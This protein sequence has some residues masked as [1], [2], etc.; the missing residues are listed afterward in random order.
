V[1]CGEREEQLERILRENSWFVDVLEIVRD[2]SPPSSAVGAGVI[3]N[4]VWDHLHG[5]RTLT[6]LNDVD[7]VYFDPADVSRARDRNLERK[8]GEQRPAIPWQVTNQAGVHL[9]YEAKFGYRI[10]PARSLADAVA[11]W[12]EPATAIAVSLAPGQS[13]RVVAPLGLDDLLGLVLRR[14]PRQITREYFLERLEKKRIRERWPLV[15]VVDDP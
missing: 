3:R 8:L 14:N 6:P 1:T 9:W 13:L 10:P 15:R 4:I 2:S 11:T 5:H 7:V 12:P